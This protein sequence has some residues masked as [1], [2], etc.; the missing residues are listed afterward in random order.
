MLV[1]V[2]QYSEFALNKELVKVK[3]RWMWYSK[4]MLK[5]ELV[6]VRVEESDLSDDIIEHLYNTPQI[7]IQEFLSD[8]LNNEI[9]ELWKVFYIAAIPVSKPYYVIIFKDST[10]LCICMNIINQGMLCH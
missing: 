3:V 8:I 4:F 1:E 7:C 9:E 2:N 10:L 5:K 6:R